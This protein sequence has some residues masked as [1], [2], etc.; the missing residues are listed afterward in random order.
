MA[1]PHGSVFFWCNCGA[2]ESSI[3]GQEPDPR[4][5][6][7]SAKGSHIRPLAFSPKKK[8]NPNGEAVKPRTCTFSKKMTSCHAYDVSNILRS[9][10]RCGTTSTQRNYTYNR[11]LISKV[12]VG[13]LKGLKKLKLYR[14]SVDFFH[15]LSI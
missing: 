14:N 3:K 4:L 15:A 2:A 6:D 10:N 12:Q 8:S 1:R 11:F 9:G 5:S 13:L 7:T